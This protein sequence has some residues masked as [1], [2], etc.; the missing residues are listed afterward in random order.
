MRFAVAA[1]ACA[2]LGLV[3]FAF[4]DPSNPTPAPGTPASSTP[5]AAASS[6]AAAAPAAAPAVPAA[7]TAA[8]APPPAP[9]PKIDFV[10]K[11]LL[12]EGYHVEM[13]NG[14]RMFCHREEI[15][16]SR[17]DGRKVCNTKEQLELTEN[18]NKL[19]LQRTQQQYASPSVR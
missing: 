9:P 19:D 18:Q 4:A 16:G 1:L 10:E 14:E 2:G 11:H 6:P 13:H 3:S 15:L 5:P 17:V 8:P 7:P 12:S